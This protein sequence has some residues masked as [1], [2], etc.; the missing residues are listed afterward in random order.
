[1]VSK[2]ILAVITS[3]YPY[4]KT[5]DLQGNPGRVFPKKTFPQCGGRLRVS[6]VSLREGAFRGIHA[7]LH[8]GFRTGSYALF[9]KPFDR[10]MTNGVL[11][12]PFVV[13]QSNHER[14]QALRPVGRIRR[15]SSLS[16][17]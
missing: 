16:F 12:N 5:L 15:T 11:L 1:M 6:L 13:S 17:G 3:G 8:S 10:L 4:R 7:D 2:G 9:D 14:V